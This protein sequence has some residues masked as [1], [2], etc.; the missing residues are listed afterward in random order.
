MPDELAEEAE[1]A[2]HRDGVFT[3]YGVASAVLGLIGV[4]AVALAVLIWS[5]HRSQADERSYQTQV[6]QAAVDWAGVL[7]N[8]NKDN[9]DVSMQK[10]HDGTVGQLNA[11]FDSAVERYRQLVQTLQSRTAGQIDSAAVET[12]HHNPP[13]PNGGRAPSPQPQPELAELAA[14]TDTVLVVATSVSENAGGDKPQ[15]VRWTLRLD[16]SEVDDKLMIS[17]LE[18][19]R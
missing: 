5:G 19:I 3:G 13:P 15:T 6:L 8:M 14:R 4:A 17:R 9:V 7:I 12:L 18:P 1:P 2:D 11:D 16:V 10:L